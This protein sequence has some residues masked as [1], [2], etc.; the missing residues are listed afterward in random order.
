MLWKCDEAVA[1]T[2]LLEQ[3]RIVSSRRTSTI[4]TRFFSFQGI[5]LDVIGPLR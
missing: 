4:S 3:D 2:V 1:N 5:T